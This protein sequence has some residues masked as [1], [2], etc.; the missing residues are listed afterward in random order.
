LQPGVQVPA[1]TTALA[2]GT[3]FTNSDLQKGTRTALIFFRGRW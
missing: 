1:F 2:D 3:E